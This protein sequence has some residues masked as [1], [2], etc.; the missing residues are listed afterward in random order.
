MTIIIAVTIFLA[1]VIGF[2]LVMK[3]IREAGMKVSEN[4]MTPPPPSKSPEEE[5]KEILDVLL[6]LNL[7][8]RKDITFSMEM[9]LKVEQIIDDLKAVLPAMM[10]RY[11]GESLTYEIKK[12]G[13]SHL[14]K[15]VKEFL[16]LSE[17]SRQH[18]LENFQTTLQSLH[19]VT[20]RSRDI[21]EKNETAEFKTMAHFL[22]G[23]FS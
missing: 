13:L 21:V 6:G 10:E 22:A 2:G 9:V 7:L 5:F 11:P 4:P 23:K 14:Y 16:D 15:T 8:I 20:H 12:I 17:D 3:K 18:Q 1:A 19:D